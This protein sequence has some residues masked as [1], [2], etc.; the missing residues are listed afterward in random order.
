MCIYLKVYIDSFKI[1]SCA[2]SS[3]GQQKLNLSYSAPWQDCPIQNSREIYESFIGY[4][5]ENFGPPAGFEERLMAIFKGIKIHRSKSN[6]GL[7]VFPIIETEVDLNAFGW[8]F[9]WNYRGAF[10]PVLVDYLT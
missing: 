8:G 1:V 5:E 6:P 2:S 7:A 10:F 4:Q 9:D 3:N